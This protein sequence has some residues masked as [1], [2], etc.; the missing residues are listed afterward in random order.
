M[1]EIKI[2]LIINILLFCSII[3]IVIGAV[4]IYEKRYM[5]L[6]GFLVKAL[7]EKN[8]VNNRKSNN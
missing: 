6:S 4:L 8:A 5:L 2:L 1:L 3:Y 7:R